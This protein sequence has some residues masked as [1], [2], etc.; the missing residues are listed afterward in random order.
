MQRIVLSPC[1]HISEYIYRICLLRFVLSPRLSVDVGEW[2]WITDTNMP[3]K[4]E[5]MWTLA[6]LPCFLVCK[7]CIYHKPLTFCLHQIFAISSTATPSQIAVD[8]P[9][10]I[11]CLARTVNNTCC[12]WN[13][14]YCLLLHKAA[15]NH[16]FN[17]P[18]TRM[19][20]WFSRRGGCLPGEAH[21]RDARTTCSSRT[22]HVGQ[23][24]PCEDI[25]QHLERMKALHENLFPQK[26]VYLLLTCRRCRPVC[27]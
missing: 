18:T 6:F 7:L 13:C 15:E 22:V 8:E 3:W 19:K 11:V 14:R 24:G 12:L 20:L 17:P 10:T 26:W 23:A 21:R 16:C 27:L 25:S 1:L 4:Y 9:L 5:G 2:A